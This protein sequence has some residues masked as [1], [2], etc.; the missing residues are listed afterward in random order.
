MTTSGLQAKIRT[1]I[2]ALYGTPA[3]SALLDLFCQALGKAIVEYIQQNATIVL[4]AND[5]QVP[6]TGLVDSVAGAV[7]GEANNKAGTIPAG[8]VQ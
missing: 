4:A 7:S 5:I 1:E 2:E 6:G 8:V 3:D